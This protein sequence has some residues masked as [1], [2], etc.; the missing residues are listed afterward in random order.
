MPQIEHIVVLMLENRSFDNVVGWLYRTE[1]PP[2][3]VPAGSSPVYDGLTTGPYSNDYKGRTL[4]VTVG[5]G[6]AAQPLRVPRLDPHEGYADVTIQLFGDDTGR[7]PTTIAPGV[8]AKMQGFARNYNA[9][10]E[11]WAELGEVMGAYLPEQLPALNGLARQYAVSDRWFSS[12]PTQTNPNRAF[13]LCGT[14][15][16][17]VVNGPMGIDL[18][19]TDTVWNALPPATSWG[20]YFHD[21]WKNGKCLTELM[22]PRL[23]AA[24][25]H[26]AFAEIQTMPA[27]YAHAQAGTLPAFSYLEPMWGYGKGTPDG[28]VGRQGTDYHPPTW[29]GPGEALVNQIY[30][31]L[32]S[33]PTLWSKTLLVITF[34]EHGG[35]YDHVDP[36][37]GAV[38]PDAHTGP[39]GFA[40]NRYGVRVPTILASPY[41]P[42]GTV[43]RAPADS[44][45]P[46]D[47]CSLIATILKWQGIDPAA[48]GLGN[49]VAVAPTFEAALLDTPRTDVPVLDVPASYATQSD[50]VLGIVSAAGVDMADIIACVDKS[51]GPMEIVK[52][53]S[54]LQGGPP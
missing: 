1:A 32:S 48:A 10:W 25:T 47:H 15:L 18:F 16:G 27:F 41:I 14:S 4:P 50:G 17:R 44:P 34:D 46:F 21:L 9:V 28:F 43:F 8:A 33:N 7:V 29:L 31:A 39:D 12:V 51:G 13:S 19:D 42:A 24:R 5:T 49:R 6:Q 45:H 52:C 38:P 23:D 3:V 53:L 26:A 35:I 37:W 40:F 30:Q 36:G 20:I 11:S 2:R 54:Q 22:F